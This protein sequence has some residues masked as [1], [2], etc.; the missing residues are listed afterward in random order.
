MAAAASATAYGS[1]APRLLL[2][3]G[4]ATSATSATSAPSATRAPTDGLP[5]HAQAVVI[6]G[7]VVGSSVAYHLTK[8]G[9]TDVVVLEA[10]ATTSGTT[11]HAAGLVGLTRN[12]STEVELSIAGA[13]LYEQLEAETGL[14]PGFKRCGSINVARTPERMEV[15]KRQLVRARSFGLEGHLLTPEECGEKYAGLDGVDLLR[16]DDLVGGVWLPM[17]GSGSPTDLTAAM[18]RGATQRGARVYER[19]AVAEFDTRRD[20]ATGRNRVTGVTT[21][22]GQTISAD[23]VVLCAGQWSRQVAA[24]HGVSIPLHSAEHFYMITQPMEGVHHSLP[25]MRDPDACTYFREW[26][27]GICAGGFELECKPIFSEGVPE[28]FE[29]ALLEDDWEHFMPLFEGR[30]VGRCG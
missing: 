25:V 17:D 10:N 18:F 11:W 5:S 4:L 19:T 28:D 29:F 6:G 2:A 8:L 14:D 27:G 22:S 9:M 24:R 20:L 30:W 21:A 23:V 16:T 12:T 26:S 1:L 7:G 13:E 3:R 15:F